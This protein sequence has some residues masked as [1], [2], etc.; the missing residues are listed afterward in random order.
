MTDP[1]E[2]PILDKIRAM[3][4]FAATTQFLY[5]F[6]DMFGLDEFD[7]DVPSFL[8]SEVTYRPSRKSYS[9]SGIAN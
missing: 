6:Y 7:V 8:N 1:T 4:E 9:A 5:L 2:P 3:W